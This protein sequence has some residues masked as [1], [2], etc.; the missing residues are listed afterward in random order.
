MAG[1]MPAGASAQTA[2]ALRGQISSPEEGL[3][4]G[5]LKSLPYTTRGRRLQVWV[6]SCCQFLRRRRRLL[7]SNRTPLGGAR[8]LKAMLVVLT[9]EENDHAGQ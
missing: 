5:V 6:I 4:E 8:A 2:S 1:V 3:M 9:N 7:D